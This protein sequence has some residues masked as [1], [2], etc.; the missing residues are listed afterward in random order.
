MGAKAVI[1]GCLGPNLRPDEARFFRDADPWGFI[2]FSRNLQNPAQC[3]ALCTDLRDAVGRDAPILIDQEGGRV[4]RMGAPY[5]HEFLPALDQ[6]Q[7]IPDPDLQA[8]AM[9]LRARLIAS[10]LRAAGI[11]VNCTPLAD[12]A[13]D[14]THAVLKNRCYGTSADQVARLARAGAEATL[15]GGV[16]PVLKHM[17]GHG[18]ANLDSHQ[19]L[20]VIEASREDLIAEDFAAFKALNDLP[21]A[22][23]AHLL[24][25]NL[26]P[27]NCATQSSTIINL[28]RQKIGFDGLLMTD[29]IS[30]NALGGSFAQR[31]Q[32]ALSAGCDV[33]LHCNG[34]ASEMVEIAT[35]TPELVDKP[36]KRA[37]YALSERQT[38]EAFD[39][40]AA[41]NRYRSILK[42]SM[43]A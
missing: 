12:I 19:D 9:F 34:D 2:L 43:H 1:Y 31:S 24:M 21:M 29:D 8:E 33:I 38:P 23:T 30:M 37:K 39:A 32:K 28:I 41:L 36:A 6:T 3:R 17:P 27:D 16:L 42:E 18:R 5:W 20:P 11:D 10:D 35:Q 40:S 13:H 4:T 26:D 7:A 14:H 25:P 22:M 15:K